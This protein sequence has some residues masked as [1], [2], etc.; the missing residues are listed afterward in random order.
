MKSPL[1]EAKRWYDQAWNDWEFIRWL[2]QEDRFYDKGCF[3]A[4]Q[5]AEK[6]LK[7]CLYACGERFV[8]IHST[9]D[10]AAKLTEF[11]PEFKKIVDA[12]RRLDRFYIPTRYPNGL[13]GGVPYKHFTKGDFEKALADTEEVMKLSQQ[14][15]K[16]KGIEL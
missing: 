14:F 3:L 15:L 4:Q 8:P 1:I 12:A 13:P 9:F 7:A 11:S 5:A 16:K 6:F 2:S 10:L